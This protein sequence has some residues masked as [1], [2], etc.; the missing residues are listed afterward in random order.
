MAQNNSLVDEMMQDYDCIFYPMC[1]K[2]RVLLY[3]PKKAGKTECED[4]RSLFPSNRTCYIHCKT[5]KQ[6][7]TTH[8]NIPEQIDRIELLD[9]LCNID[10]THYVWGELA[11]EDVRTCEG[12]SCNY[13]GRF[14]K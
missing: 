5:C 13:C 6:T 2:A 3:C 1:H 10:L 14:N 7:I 8:C 9:A 11:S 4:Y 12:I